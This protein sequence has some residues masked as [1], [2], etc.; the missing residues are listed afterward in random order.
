MQVLNQSIGKNYALYHGDSCEVLKGIPSNSI[1]YTITSPPFSSLY[2]YSASD[3]DLGNCS[4]DDA[5]FQHFEFL[6]EELLRVTVPG[7]LI[8]L[9]CMNLPSTLQHNGYIGIR[10]FRGDLIR[11]FQ[12]KGWIYHSEV[13]IWKDPVIA[14]QRTKAIGLLH[15]QAVKD[16]SLS[17]QGIPDYLVT[18]RKS[19][20][21]PDPIE[22]EFTY[23]VGENPPKPTGNKTTDS[24]NIWQRYASPIWMDINPSN[25]LQFR[26]AKESDQ[27]K[28]ICPL[29]LDVIERGLQL[30]SLPGETVLDPFNG[31][32]SSG[33]VA[34]KAKRKYVG[35][36]LKESYYKL[37]VK[38]LDQAEVESVQPNLLD[39]MGYTV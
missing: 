7:R 35:C 1:H 30:W 37:A 17:R 21:N 10:D 26:T 20:K 9:H 27:E 2:T 5:F 12:S 25:T 15:K 28:H 39:M 3:R 4:G 6:V 24:I 8:S 11:I 23:F 29:Q 14:M 33:Y 16:S 19:G 18:M 13:C 22:G 38:N 31:I 34:L 32:G 36:E